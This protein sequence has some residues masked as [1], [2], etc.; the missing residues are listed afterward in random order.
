MADIG[1]FL[2][3]GAGIMENAPARVQGFHEGLGR[4]HILPNSAAPTSPGLRG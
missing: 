2:A 1:A 4:A 3:A